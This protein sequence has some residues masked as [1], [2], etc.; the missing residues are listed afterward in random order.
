MFSPAERAFVEGARVARLATADGEGRPHAVPV[1]FAFVDERIVSPVDEKP[2]AAAPDSLRR[3]RDVRENPRVS[4]VVDRYAEDWA[5]LGWVQVRGT[6]A[7][8]NPDESAHGTAVSALREK[9][10]Q[11]A[12]HALDARPL[13]RIDPGHVVSWGRL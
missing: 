3:V 5:E 9:Y 6:A 4:L 7:V 12:D 1:C 10:D 2:K 13:L 11:Y 8:V